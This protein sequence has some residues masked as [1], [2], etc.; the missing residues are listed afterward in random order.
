M[1][2]ILFM[3]HSKGNNMSYPQTA[4]EALNQLKQIDHD[5]IELIIEQDCYGATPYLSG[6]TDQGW[7]IVWHPDFLFD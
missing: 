1:K 3:P 7:S 5:Y 4:I 2:A 6:K